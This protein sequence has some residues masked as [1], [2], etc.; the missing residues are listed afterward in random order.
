MNE[1]LTRSDVLNHC[2]KVHEKNVLCCYR[3]EIG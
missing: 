2:R 1:N 3:Y